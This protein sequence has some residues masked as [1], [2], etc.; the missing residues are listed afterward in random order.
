MHNRLPA[1]RRTK[2]RHSSVRTSLSSHGVSWRTFMGYLSYAR[3]R[4]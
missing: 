3:N 2:A 4:A 1:V